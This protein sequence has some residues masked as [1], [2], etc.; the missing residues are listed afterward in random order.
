MIFSIWLIVQVYKTGLSYFKF[1]R[2]NI[3][4]NKLN[5]QKQTDEYLKNKLNEIK[6]KHIDDVT[7]E[8]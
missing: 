4:S 6:K 1:I 3:I 7:Y 5:S 2:N 8:K